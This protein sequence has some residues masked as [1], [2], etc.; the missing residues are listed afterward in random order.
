MAASRTVRA[1]GPAGSWLCEMGMMPE[2]LISA[3]VGLIPTIPFALDG[4]TT[5]PS[6]SLPTATAQK[7]AETAAPEPELEPQGFRSR[8]YGFRVCPPRALHPLLEWLERMVSH[9][10]RV[11]L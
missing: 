4:H 7:L 1:I 3:S 8:T 5:E 2:R 10:L 11:G 9:P 6:V